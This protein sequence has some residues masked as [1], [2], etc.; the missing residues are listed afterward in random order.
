M[1]ALVDEDVL[2]R[3]G[4]I[5]IVRPL[6]TVRLPATVQGVLA[7]RIDR[8]PPP[9]KEL[10][11]M[12]A[13][14]GREFPR[15]LVRKLADRPEAELDAI[16]SD[17]QSAEFIYEQP[18]VADLEYTFKHALTREVAYGTLLGERRKLLHQRIAR[19]IEHGFPALAEAEPELLADHFS[20]AGLPA[21]ASRWREHAGDRAAARSAYN[22]AI[23]Q[24]NAGIEETERMPV[25]AERD[26]RQLA[27]LLKLGP[28]RSV[29]DGPQHPEV[30]QLYQRARGLSESLGDGPGLFK[31]A[32]GLWLTSSLGRTELA[33]TRAEDLVSL[34]SRLQDDGLLL[35]AFHCRWST[36]FFRGEMSSAIDGSV[37]V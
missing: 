16:L 23:A 27:L 33:R 1:Q 4:A 10:L 9:A 13:V 34:G 20:Q 2:R 28:A 17:L 26:E 30:E 21:A 24:F 14:I 22:E 36:A 32:W 37:E 15:C 35:E 29:V 18:A 7:A 25:G 19:E 3:N 12:L 11:Q 8:L 5:T 6:S 31:A